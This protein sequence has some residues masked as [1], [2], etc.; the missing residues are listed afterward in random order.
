[1]NTVEIRRLDVGH[2][3]LTLQDDELDA[4]SGGLND[5]ECIDLNVIGR[6]EG[7][8]RSFQSVSGFAG[9]GLGSAHAVG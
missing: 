4:V 1:M 7:A 8:R 9:D 2:D 3:M 5:V 6:Y